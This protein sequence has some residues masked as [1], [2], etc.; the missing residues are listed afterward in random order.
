M[1]ARRYIIGA[2]TLAIWTTSLSAQNV[3]TS[4]TPGNAPVI[5]AYT[6]ST[7]VY[8]AE[9]II[10]EKK[11]V[12]YS[13]IREA[14]VAWAKD[15]W[16]TIDLRHRQNMPL[17]YPLEGTMSDGERYSL[18]GL[19]MEGIKSEEITPYEFNVIAGWKDPF[20]I[21][22]NLEEIYRRSG[23]DTIYDNE[24]NFERVGQ[25]TSNILQIQ[26][27]EQWYFD[28]Q[29]STM[30]VRIVALAPVFYEY[31]DEFNQPLPSPRPMIP[32]VVHFP[33]C[34]RL[35]ATHSVYNPKN[36]A[37][38]MSFDDLFMQRRFSSTIIAESNVFGNRMLTDY[39]LGQDVLLEAERIKND[40]FIMEHDLWEY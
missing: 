21:V 17:R 32:F 13:Y 12:P 2:A 8:K 22:T 38:A 6:P 4:V 5:T 1:K 36:D 29:H 26:L 33:Q 31:F 28:K 34:R 30:N 39:K 16:R 10:P 24:G 37:Q 11:P 14:D 18:F 25:G 23:G 35:F 40:L 15:V 19:L 3:N 20:S 9:T 27:Q 7:D